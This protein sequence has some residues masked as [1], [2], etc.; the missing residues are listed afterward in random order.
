MLKQDEPQDYVIATGKTYSVK[1]LVELAFG[2]AG[3]DYRDYVVTDEELYRPA[4]IYELRGDFTKA[5][6][7]L[8]W[9][10]EV[11]FEEMIKTMVDA[12]LERLKR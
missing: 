12:D 10:P 5:R 7:I 11:S 1:E 6:K 4:E 3:L 9:E 8:G 2:Y